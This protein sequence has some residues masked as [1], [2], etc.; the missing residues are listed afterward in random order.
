M[1]FQKALRPMMYYLRTRF[2]IDA[3]EK[4]HDIFMAYNRLIEILANKLE[5]PKQGTIRLVADDDTY[6]A[7]MGQSVGDN[8]KNEWYNV[9]DLADRGMDVGWMETNHNAHLLHHNKFLIFSRGTESTKKA[10]G[11]FCGAG[12]LTGTAFN[13]NFENFYYITIPKVTK[14]FQEQYDDY[15]WM[16]STWAED[17]PAENISL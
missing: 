17:M 5:S 12:N 4:G 2:V 1:G 9:K 10:F 14:A 16:K 3:T 11:V 13:S 7:G 6:W 15:L 8:G